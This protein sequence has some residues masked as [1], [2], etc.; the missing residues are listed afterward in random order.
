M[1]DNKPNGTDNT[2]QP[3]TAN[4]QAPGPEFTIQRI[5][6]KDLSFETPNTPQNFRETWQPAVNVELNVATEK[7]EGTVFEVKLSITANVTTNEKAAFLAE[8]HQAGI[9]NINGFNEAQLQRMLGSYC[10]TVLFPYAREAISDL[11]GRG[12][13]P[14]LYLA[15]INFEAL[16]E[17]QLQQQQNKTKDTADST[18]TTESK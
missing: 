1:T 2:A 9:F 11:V 17:Q 13:F 4:T 10:P 18:E 7:L 6:V 5:Y 14:P 15:P 8:V 16:F 3:Q 12:G